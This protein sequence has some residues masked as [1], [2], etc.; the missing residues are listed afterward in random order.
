[1]EVRDLAAVA[2]QRFVKITTEIEKF[3]HWMSGEGRQAPEKAG[4]EGRFAGVAD[5]SLRRCEMAFV[6]ES[7]CQRGN[8][9]VDEH[10]P[11]GIEEITL[12]LLDKGTDDG[13]RLL[14]ERDV[15]VEPD[16][17]PPYRR[18]ELGEAGIDTH[19]L[20]GLPQLLHG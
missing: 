6:D 15:L 18:L 11:L 10:E 20:E 13:I 12:Q 19:P 8:V 4:A 14:T 5:C 1:M 9:V 3:V 16:K 2:P 17:L 7:P